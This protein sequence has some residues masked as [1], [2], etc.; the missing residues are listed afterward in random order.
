MKQAV[1]ALTLLALA[2]CGCQT[3]PEEPAAVDTD[4]AIQTTDIESLPVGTEQQCIERLTKVVDVDYLRAHDV[5]VD[6]P[7]SAEIAIEE[8]I[9]KVCADADPET[10]V[11]EAAHEVI[12]EVAEA[13][14]T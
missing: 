11:H 10:E 7:P 13:L 2:L 3:T 12:H 1:F 4:I 9:S 14:F 5:I 8:A 6:D